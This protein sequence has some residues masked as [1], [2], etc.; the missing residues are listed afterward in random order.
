MRASDW[1]LS[2]LVLGEVA[3]VTYLKLRS[4]LKL[5]SDVPLSLE[6]VEAPAIEVSSRVLRARRRLHQCL[7]RRGIDLSAVLAAVTVATAATASPRAADA[8]ARLILAL[9]TG[10]AGAGASLSGNVL[11]L[12]EGA[13]SIMCTTR[14]A[15]ATLLLLAATLAGA[16][17]FV[18]QRATSTEAVRDAQES[19]RAKEP[20]PVEVKGR[21]LAP[22]G[23]PLAVASVRAQA[24]NAGLTDIT[25]QGTH[26][27]FAPVDLPESRQVRAQR[28]Y[29]KT[30]LKP[31]VRTMLVPVP[32]DVP[33]ARPGAPAPPGAPLLRDRGLLAWCGQLIEAVFGESSPVPPN[34]AAT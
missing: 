6:V 11:T 19:T 12:A 3:I 30:V 2:G 22:E 7:T 28:L 33:G 14:L 21:V 25:Q 1:A 31:A 32:R 26:I 24:R 20:H 13:R 23:Q 29:P 16:G 17:A 18:Q 9:A 5:A 4:R 8:T 10:Q 15:I 34:V 27:R